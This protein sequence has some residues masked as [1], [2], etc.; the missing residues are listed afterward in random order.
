MKC[1]DLNFYNFYEKSNFN[2]SHPASFFNDDQ[3]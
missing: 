1:L 2:F 3:L